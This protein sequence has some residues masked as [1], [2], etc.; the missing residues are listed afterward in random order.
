MS[1]YQP[2]RK[3]TPYSQGQLWGESNIRYFVKPNEKK[4]SDSTQNKK[5]EKQCKSLQ[6]NTTTKTKQEQKK[7]KDKTLSVKKAPLKKKI[8]KNKIKVT[9]KQKPKQ[10]QTSAAPEITSENFI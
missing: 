2:R 7:T 1:W 9:T 8:T 3:I 4:D 5:T 10:Q 6:Q